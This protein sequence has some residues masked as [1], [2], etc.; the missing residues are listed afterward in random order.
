MGNAEACKACGATKAPKEFV[1]FRST[2]QDKSVDLADSAEY[3]I[4][5]S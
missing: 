5:F 1:R 2:N 4:R 3:S